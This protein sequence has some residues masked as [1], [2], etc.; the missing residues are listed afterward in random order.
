MSDSSDFH[1]MVG[2]QISMTA[3]EFGQNVSVLPLRQTSP[4]NGIFH[5]SDLS[6]LL[7]GPLSSHRSELHLSRLRAPRARRLGGAAGRGDYAGAG[8][9]EH[10]CQGV[11]LL[12]RGVSVGWRH[13]AVFL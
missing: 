11:Q 9:Q 2:G 12:Q 1:S 3:S 7:L 10:G 13:R 6:P 8:Q 4:A 5:I